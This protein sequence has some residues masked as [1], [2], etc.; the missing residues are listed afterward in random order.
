M[1]REWYGMINHSAA[2][3]NRKTYRLHHSCILLKKVKESDIELKHSQHGRVKIS[4][5]S[6]LTYDE[7][8]KSFD[9]WT[10]QT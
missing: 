7:K 1:E 2:N 3:T 10:V 6:T 9:Y 5:K 8:K 4:F